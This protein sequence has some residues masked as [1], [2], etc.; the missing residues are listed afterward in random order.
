MKERMIEQRNRLTTFEEITDTRHHN[1]NKSVHRF[2]VHESFI[3]RTVDEEE[4]TPMNAL[5][6]RRKRSQ[7]LDRLTALSQRHDPDGYFG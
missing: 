2:I 6:D 5:K 7:L 1:Q 3:Q 4:V